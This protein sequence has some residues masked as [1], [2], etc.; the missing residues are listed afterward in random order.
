MSNRCNKYDKVD[1]HLFPLIC[2]KIISFPIVIGFRAGLYIAE[3]SQILM[4]QYITKNIDLR[5]GIYSPKT[6]TGN[7]RCSLMM[8]V[9]IACRYLMRRVKQIG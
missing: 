4:L 3:L 5:K 7:G 6:S 8:G 9:H 2:E 1:V